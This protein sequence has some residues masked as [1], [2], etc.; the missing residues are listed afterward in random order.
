MEHRAKRIA[1]MAGVGTLAVCL[2]LGAFMPPHA[3]AESGEQTPATQFFNSETGAWEQ[4]PHSQYGKITV[5]YDTTQGTWQDPGLDTSDGNDNGTHQNGTYQ[6]VIP[7]YISHEGLN[8]GAI[9]T[10][11]TY[12]I[13][14]R[15][16]IPEGKLIRVDAEC[17]PEIN[18]EGNYHIQQTTH[19]EKTVW[20][21]A[22]CMGAV[23][24]DGSLSGTPSNDTISTEGTMYAAGSFTGHVFYTAEMAT[25]GK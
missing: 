2:S 24:E 14:V 15:G 23:H 7:T 19:Q 16:V 21:P 3:L 8:A 20:S 11:D 10:S 22:D 1:Q 9:Q 4:G 5:T 18:S 25:Q 17:Q 13:L 12:Q 6:V